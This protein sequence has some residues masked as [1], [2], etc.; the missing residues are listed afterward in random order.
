M[1]PT[2]RR[3][4]YAR[5]LLPALVL[6][7]GVL[8]YG[9]AVLTPTLP[10]MN[11]GTL[12]VVSR[13]F[14]PEAPLRAGDTIVRVDDRTPDEWASGGLSALG[15]LAGHYQVT[16]ERE[17]YVYTID[18]AA[19][20]IP[21][22]AA[23]R[24]WGGALA[25][26]LASLLVSTL[27]GQLSGNGAAEQGVR[28][29]FLGL[30]LYFCIL[31]LTIAPPLSWIFEPLLAPAQIAGLGLLSGI[32]VFFL[33]YRRATR[34]WHPWLVP[35]AIYAS[36]IAGAALPW[37]LAG[38]TPLE[39]ASLLTE[40]IG[41]IV[42]ATIALL[43]IALSVRAYRRNREPLVRAQFRW[44]LWGV[45]VGVIP[46]LALW[47]LPTIFG[48]KQSIPLTL[49]LLPM[50]A[51]P[52]SF[53][54]A[55]LRYRLLDVDVVLS[56]TIV[57]LAL[58]IGLGIGYVL[59]TG[60]AGRL[61]P[62]LL[63]DEGGTLVPFLMTLLL[64]AL[65]NPALRFARRVVDGV[66]YPGRRAMREQI[67]AAMRELRD[68][69]GWEALLSLLDSRL[70][71]LIGVGAARVLVWEDGRFVQPTTDKT[72]DK[73][74][75]RQGEGTSDNHSISLAPRLSG[76]Y[77]LAAGVRLPPDWP[78]ERPI[79][80]LPW[81]QKRDFVQAGE[82]PAEFEPLRAAG[83]QLA[84]VLVAGG[85]PVGLYALGR[86]LS[87]D[88][89]D[90][91]VIG[92]LS[93][94]AD[95]IAGAVENANLL[96]QTAAQARLRHELTIARRIQESLLPNAALCHGSLE[97]AAL[98]LPASD[99][100]G[101]LYAAHALPDGSLAL[102]VGDISG[103][104]VGAALL[105]AVTSTM[106]T[107]IGGDE[108]PPALLAR[109]NGLL[110]DYTAR[111]RQNVALCYL[112]VEPGDGRGY[113][114]A[115]AS[116]GAIPPLLRRVDGALEW[117]PVGGL[118][119]GTAVEQPSYPPATATLGPGDTLLL[120]TDGL[121]EARGADGGLLSFA[122]VERAL[123]EAPCRQGAHAVTEHLIGALRGFTAGREL[124][125][126]VTVMVVQYR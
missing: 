105:M 4:R 13:P 76:A 16:I 3:S 31:P 104:G 25:L 52:F 110:R 122:G 88:W 85:R 83:Y 108:S 23:L 79:V 11:D 91:G 1:A 109:L 119:L 101:D 54:M 70:P 57:Y 27:I 24:M 80:L 62:W 78:L 33:G 90:S 96:E 22:A 114:I 30:A 111:N 74:T 103:K 35:L 118:P 34:L 120:C 100:G 39:R 77:P 53:A 26:G 49:A 102:A 81:A 93:Q 18:V 5:L 44:L 42:A 48:V 60:I 9:Y 36:G 61:I 73:E 63:G 72:K 92:A 87:G 126:D 14:H 116:A 67:D 10:F 8:A 59:L 50:L 38:G 84:F 43:A 113:P 7:L 41:N 45:L 21:L 69:E 2:A 29:A 37:A 123:A 46:W 97:V 115:A 55:I 15:D 12:R 51:L 19:E 95:R 20:R 75:R 40:Q 47:V 121:L 117:L 71:R 17:S 82:L 66:L 99:V 56:R 58:T 98:S 124:E 112:R 6:I 65:F 32:V 89:Y 64:A 94:L 86:P 68:V 107:T 28:I 125:D 106:L